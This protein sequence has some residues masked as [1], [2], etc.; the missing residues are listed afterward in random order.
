MQYTVFLVMA[1]IAAVILVATAIA[2]AHSP[3]SRLTSDLMI[4]IFLSLGFIITNTLE[5]VLPTET[6]TMLFAKLGYPF[7]ILTPVFVLFFT[8]TFTGNER[9]VAGKRKLPLFLVPLAVCALVMTE[10]LHGLIWS[11]ISYIP[12]NGMLA[13]SVR[14]GPFFWIGFLYTLGLLILCAV[15]LLLEAAQS[16]PVY[17]RQTLLVIVGIGIPLALHAVYSLK[18]IPGLTKNF[19][20]IAYAAAGVCFVASIR[21]HR[22]LDLVPIARGLLI[23]EITDAVIVVDVSGRIVDVNRAAGA[24]LGPAQTVV[25]ANVDGYPELKRIL[26]PESPAPAQEEVSFLVAGA[27]RYFGARVSPIRGKAGA[28]IGSIVLLRDVTDAHILLEEKNNLIE[29]LMRA[30]MEIKTLQGIIPICMYCKK[31]RD[32]EGYWHQVEQFMSDHSSATFSH[33]LCPECRRKLE[34]NDYRMK[35]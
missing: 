32:D 2:V 30:S 25:G 23:E 12:V 27:L 3:R 20:P 14:Y 5:L 10:P 26:A 35:P 31:I 29:E 7:A 33:G 21:Q 19:S 28:P 16:Q 15:L 6:G 22:F 9:W 8:L 11:Y 4:S 17:R 24:L 13:M 34:A 18:L 1:P